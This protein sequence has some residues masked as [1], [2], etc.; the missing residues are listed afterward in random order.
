MMVQTQKSTGLSNHHQPDD[1]FLRER[2]EHV[3]PDYYDRGVRE[4]LFQRIWHR[5]R[6]PV[7]QSFLTGRGGRLL[8][9]GCHGGY[10]S[11]LIESVSGATVTGIDISSEAIAYARAHHPNMTFIV[12]DLQDPFP[13]PD[14]SFESVT[15]FDVLEHVPKLEVVLREVHRVLVPGGVL[16]IGVPRDTRLFRTVWA[17]WT[18]LR[19]AVWQDVH[20]HDF[21][22]DQLRERV[23]AAG[24]RL[25]RSNI[26]HWGMY[27]VNQFQRL[28]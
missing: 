14:A 9:L 8:D 27:L 11:S 3:P 28:P 19:G 13:F 7:L 17:A 20:V 25:V 12:G 15:A 1:S 2:H 23:V 5:R 6:A 26:S 16:I 18:R 21:T 24:Y 10:V 4:S 22:S